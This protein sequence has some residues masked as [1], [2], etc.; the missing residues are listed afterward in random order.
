MIVGGIII[1]QTNFLKDT[2][3]LCDSV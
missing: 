1:N 3:L 2:Q